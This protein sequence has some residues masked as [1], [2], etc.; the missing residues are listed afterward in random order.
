MYLFVLCG[1]ENKQRLFRFT[2]LTGSNVTADVTCITG[3]GQWILQWKGFPQS[4]QDLT[5]HISVSIINFYSH[6][7]QKIAVTV[8]HVW[9]MRDVKECR[10][11]TEHRGRA[12]APVLFTVSVSLHNY[13]ACLRSLLLKCWKQRYG[14]HYIS[15]R[16]LL[17]PSPPL[18]SLFYSLLQNLLPWQPVFNT[19]LGILL[20]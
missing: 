4:W 16:P 15:L 12:Q 14:L 5:I 2:A 6:K 9:N 11:R 1:S 18:T 8:P 17:L 3:Q 7:K 20:S 19:S 10:C 13:A